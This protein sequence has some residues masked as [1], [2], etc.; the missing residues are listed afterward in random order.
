MGLK[1]SLLTH[2]T[3]QG[4]QGGFE[5]LFLLLYYIVLESHELGMFQDLKYCPN[6]S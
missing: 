1:A 3:N 5:A 2:Y 6:S 4:E